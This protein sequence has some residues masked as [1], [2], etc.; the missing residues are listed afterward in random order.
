MDEAG[1]E[2]ERAA[3]LLRHQ[4]VEAQA[5][6]GALDS[7]ISALRRMQEHFDGYAASV[8][9]V[10]ENA[11]S[12]KLS[13]IKGPVSTLIR[14]PEKY[15]VAIETALGSA[16]QNIVVED[17]RAA[18]AAIGALKAA[19]AGRATFYPVS[20][21]RAQNRFRELEAA[22]T[23]KGFEGFADE[24]VKTDAAYGEILRSLLGRIAVFSDL[25]TATDFARSQSWRVR[26]VTLDGQQIN[27]GGS[28]TGGS[29]KHDSGMLSRS[30]QI[31]RLTEE[32][33]K[34]EKRIGEIRRKLEEGEE[35]ARKSTAYKTASEEKKKLVET[36][37]RSEQIRYDSLE[38]RLEVA[39]KRLEQLRADARNLSGEQSRD[40]ADIGRLE[41]ASE[42]GEKA[43]AEIIDRRKELEGIVAE[44]SRDLEAINER[45]SEVQVRLAECRKDRETADAAIDG[46]LREREAIELE[47]ER[48]EAECK[49]LLAESEAVKTQLA[50]SKTSS[51]EA[52][53][54]IREKENRRRKL[55]DEGIDYE[56]RLNELRVKQKEISNRKNLIFQAHS[57]NETKL[58]QL[59]I[60]IDKMTERLWD[61]YEL[62][63][64]TA[65]ALNYPPVTYGERAGVAQRLT[66]LRGQIR[67]LGSVN[68]ASIDE[69]KEV[70][71]RHDAMKRQLD[72]LEAAKADIQE[73]ISGIETEMKMMFSDAFEK[74]NRN[75]GEVFRELFGGGHAHLVLSDPDDV[76][77]CG[78][79]IHVAPPGKMIKSLTLLSGGEQA[80]VAIALLFALIRVNPSPFC[81]FDEIEAALDEVNVTRVARYVKRYS[82]NMQII[83]ITHRR[84]TMEIADTL[85]GVTM[86]RHGISKVF[87]LD[88]NDIPKEQA[89]MLTDGGR[90]TH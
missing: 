35:I 7:R 41:I 83:M 6:A 39:E 32:K 42:K 71:E 84:G 68:V 53:V 55:E 46:N 67:G 57:K 88:V 44:L 13:G 77:N 20:S 72:D 56:R 12:G 1:A 52:A 48:R 76:L 87:T 19:G 24:L 33:E 50:A 69:Y 85:Y 2:N 22:A 70:K 86:P 65:A 60:D 66:E 34:I 62:T 5:E 14:V 9:Y 30:G 23:A 4:L 49:R 58:E 38:A 78:I 81:I 10:M 29:A 31:D 40:E 73:L 16:L 90:P 79:E 21:V 45:I 75:F 74:I 63:R 27:A 37:R 47:M 15:T 17:E 18:K 8:R 26:C 82:E 80:F 61:E 36:L 3:A 51:G 89:D 59:R 54:A 11:K 25:N 43:I 28:F 64:T